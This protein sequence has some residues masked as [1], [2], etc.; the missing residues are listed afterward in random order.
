M[1]R[2]YHTRPNYMD[3]TDKELD[4]F[5][6]KIASQV[7]EGLPENAYGLLLREHFT[8]AWEESQFRGQNPDD[9]RRMW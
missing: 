9:D 4:F 5:R 6:E 2:K 7:N 8:A 1:S 3:C